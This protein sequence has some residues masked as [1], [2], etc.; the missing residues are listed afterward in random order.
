MKFYTAK[1][2]YKTRVLRTRP[3]NSKSLFE[4]DWRK[5]Y[6]NF[7]DYF[8]CI[9]IFSAELLICY[10]TF[11]NFKHKL[12]LKWVRSWFDVC[13]YTKAQKSDLSCLLAVQNTHRRALLFTINRHWIYW[14]FPQTKLSSIYRGKFLPGSSWNWS[15][16]AKLSLSILSYF[17]FAIDSGEILASVW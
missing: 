16:Q 14:I 11:I 10:Q 12:I 6:H 1:I 13:F 4:V 17:T 2:K 8:C 3:T 15:L 7:A 5:R 9:R